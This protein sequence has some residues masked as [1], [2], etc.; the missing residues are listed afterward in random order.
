MDRITVRVAVVC[1]SLLACGALAGAIGIELAGRTAP[2][3]L[4]A[5]ASFCLGSIAGMLPGPRSGGGRQED[6]HHPGSVS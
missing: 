6:H 1:L 5:L 4:Y 2:P 3:A